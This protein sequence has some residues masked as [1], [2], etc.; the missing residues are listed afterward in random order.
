LPSSPS[1]QFGIHTNTYFT[2]FITVI[3][4]IKTNTINVYSFSIN[5]MSSKTS[6]TLDQTTDLHK[7]VQKKPK[8]QA[9]IPEAYFN[10]F[11]RVG[12]FEVSIGLLESLRGSVTVARE[13]R[14]IC[15]KINVILCKWHDLFL[16]FGLI[17]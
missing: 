11:T 16:A 4:Q 10:S 14:W 8:S 7:Q 15:S 12:V 17:F 3:L 1:P 2:G 6:L 13:K 5:K 9:M